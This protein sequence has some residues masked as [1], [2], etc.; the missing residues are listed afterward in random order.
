MLSDWFRRTTPRGGRRSEHAVT[1]AKHV[2]AGVE[3]GTIRP[4]SRL[5][6]LGKI[7]LVGVVGLIGA[8]L[9]G[10]IAGLQV[11]N[12]ESAAQD[13]DALSDVER[14]AAEL[15]YLDAD[16][17]G[18]QLGVLADVYLHGPEVALSGERAVNRTGFVEA[19]SAARKVIADFPVDRLT[20]D[21][22]PMFRA[23]AQQYE[24]FFAIDD[25]LIA[26]YK[27]GDP[28][29]RT[30]AQTIIND[31]EGSDA[32]SV[33][34]DS[35]DKF[36]ASLKERGTAA[37]VAGREAA[38]RTYVLLVVVD[39]LLAALI[40]AVAYRIARPIQRAV[41]S[42]RTSLVAMGRG[43]LTVPAEAT[44]RDEIGEMARASE[45]TRLAMRDLIGEV[46]ACST[47]VGSSS[48]ELSSTARL[49]GTSSETSAAQL[50]RVTSSAGEVSHSIRTVA[51]GTEEI[52]A[53]IR[54]IS[55]SANAAA[56]RRRDG[57]AGRRPHERH[58]R[59]AR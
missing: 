35:T 44:T 40:M 38:T 21:E 30:Q 42:V 26:L 45:E 28:A 46:A 51:A 4:E 49:V 31:G 20:E 32:W 17:S 41:E 25:K 13:R 3:P 10:G 52:A 5:G 56:G 34:V 16:L 19:E 43:Y 54:E 15:R 47:A 9:L 39:V 6:I 18:W 24:T 7:A 55:A 29:K 58:R 50:D 48:T 8:V 36:M 23:I 27:T 2:H 33:L 59:Q 11:A 1:A 14:E 22:K 37:T 53:S 57:R 12:L